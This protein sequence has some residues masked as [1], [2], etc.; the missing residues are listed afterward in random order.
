MVRRGETVAVESWGPP[1]SPPFDLPALEGLVGG[2]IWLEPMIRA[3]LYQRR[4]AAMCS[5]LLRNPDL[6]IGPP[7]ERRVL[8]SR[9][10]IAGARTTAPTFRCY[11]TASWAFNFTIANREGDATTGVF[12]SPP[13]GLNQRRHPIDRGPWAPSPKGMHH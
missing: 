12:V 9:G 13:H 7:E 8:G 11:W 1:R 2:H 6:A 10:D 5:S 3:R 4:R